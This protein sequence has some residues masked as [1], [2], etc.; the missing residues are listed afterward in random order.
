MKP[1]NYCWWVLADPDSSLFNKPKF[2]IKLTC[3]LSILIT[4]EW[5]ASSGTGHF[6]WT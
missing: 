3:Y 6:V 4:F 5:V 2:I 1:Y